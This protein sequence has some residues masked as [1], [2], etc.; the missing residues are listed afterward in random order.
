M[1]PIGTQGCDVCLLGCHCGTDL[2]PVADD[3]HDPDPVAAPRVSSKN[4]GF[5]IFGGCEHFQPS[6]PARRFNMDSKPETDQN[7][8]PYDTDRVRE[9]LKHKRKVR[10]IRSCFPCRHRKVRCDG[11]VPCASCVQRS[12]PE[13]CRVP[14][15]SSSVR[16][17]SEDSELARCSHRLYVVPGPQTRTISSVRNTK[18][19]TCSGITRSRTLRTNLT[20]NHNPN[21]N[22][23]T[24]A[25]SP[26]NPDSKQSKT[27][28]PRSK[29]IS[30]HQHAPQKARRPAPAPHDGPA[31]P[32]ASTSS[33]M[34]LAP[35]SSSAATRT[36]RWRWGVGKRRHQAMLCFTRP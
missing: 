21:L 7:M 19:M 18:L 28:L 23:Q 14:K 26:S 9:L 16:A 30:G 33:R 13:L 15:G 29:P 17:A 2:R 36:R 3:Q 24:H 35:P 8:Y 34:P 1:L 27:S 11:H 10:G 25:S 4:D 12:H 5:S 6:F 20:F 22:L 31:N 32:P